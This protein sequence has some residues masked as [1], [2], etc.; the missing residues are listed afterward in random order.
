[1][2]LGFRSELCSGCR[3]CE[4]VCAL[5][6]KDANN[7]KKGAIRIK[8]NF[9]A[10]GRYE[11]LLCDQCG[12]CAEVCPVDAIEERDGAYIIDPEKCTNCGICVE[13]CPNDAIFVHS[14][15]ETPIKCVN[16]GQCVVYCPRNAVYDEEGDVVLEK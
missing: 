13:E 16:C 15:L 1:M 8:G 9:P 6:N 14:D 10:P 7:P 4:L 11:A 12:V 5:E 3:V 2:R